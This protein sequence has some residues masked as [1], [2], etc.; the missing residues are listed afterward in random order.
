M[1]F[2]DG[3]LVLNQVKAFDDTLYQQTM[4]IQVNFCLKNPDL[5]L[6]PNTVAASKISIFTS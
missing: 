3:L 6:V 2:M 5:I 1:S 4:T